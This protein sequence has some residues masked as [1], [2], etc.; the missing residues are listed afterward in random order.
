MYRPLFAPLLLAAALGIGA[1]A[2]PV[3]PAVAQTTVASVNGDPITGREVEQRARVERLIFR[4]NLSRGQV[5]ETL[6]E[7]RVKIAEGRRL[8]MRVN[9]EFLDDLIGR[10]ASGNRQT[11]SEFEAALGRA[12]I[13]IDSLKER[14]R[15]ETVWSEVL[16]QRS[17]SGGATNAEIDAE[18]ERRVA[19]GDAKVTDYVLRQVIFVVAPGTGG[20]GQKQREAA[21]ARGRFSDCESG[22]DYLRT[23]RDVAVKERV[24]RTSTD[25][26]ERMADMIAKTPVGRL[27]PSYPSEQGIEMLAVCE[28]FERQDTGALRSRIEEELN[29]KRVEG[30]ADGYLKE[31]KGKAEIVRR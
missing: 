31:L 8:G 27:T 26:S 2:L 11:K 14:L 15:A 22:V 25:L 24:S 17:R 4:R 30:R 29:R 10:Y 5:I 3:A 21:A 7:D 13:D 12:G 28:K 1:A 23:L 16:K 20:A 6:I 9:A 19:K 18:L